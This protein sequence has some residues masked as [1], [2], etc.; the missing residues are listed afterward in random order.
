MDIVSLITQ[1]GGTLGLAIFAI[2]M[3][4]RAHRERLRDEQDARSRDKDE[5]QLLLDVVQRNSEMWNNATKSMSEVASGLAILST[6]LNDEQQHISDIRT[7]LAARPCVVDDV[8]D[9]IKGK[10][11]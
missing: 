1:T 6:V 8:L 9:G 5:R 3:L 10:V 7:L 2:W 11:R 4:E